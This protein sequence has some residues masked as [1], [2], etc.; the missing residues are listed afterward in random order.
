VR[1]T[2]FG[3]GYVGLTTG[4]MFAWLG[5]RVTLVDINPAKVA[6]IQAG[7]PPLF[8]E[9][10]APLLKAVRTQGTLDATEDPAAA[11]EADV[12]FIAVDT[13]PAPDGS[14]DMR[15][16]EAAS[17]AMGRHVDGTRL[18]VVVTKSTVPIGTA[19]LVKIW[20]EDGWRAAH[21]GAPLPDTVAV[22]SNPEF[23]REGQALFDSFYP[24]RVVVGADDPRAADVLETLYRPILAQDFPPPPGLPRPPE[25]TRVP[26]VR[27]DRVSAE[28]IKYAANAFLATKISFANEMARICDEVGAD[29]RLVTEA[30]GLDSR[31][32][33]QFLEAGVGWGGSCFGK[34][35]SALIH[36]AREYGLEPHLI[37]A[38]VTVNQIQRHWVVA[39]LQDALKTLRGRRVAL[40][41]LAFKPG[42][43]DLRD[44]PALTVLDDLLAVG[45]R[46]TAY[47]PVAA[48]R[49]QR[50]LAGR[51]VRFA[52]SALEAATGADA[53]A[54][55]TA[56]PEFRAVDLERLKAVMA[57]PVV[58]D[59]RN[60]FEP[61]D[62][63]ARGF[64]YRGV[65][66]GV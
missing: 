21:G 2:V 50:E 23:L 60:L 38:A 6:A 13:P 61:A 4:V 31:I 63:R 18:Q 28:M 54:I 52:A 49:A 40:W 22:A 8:E 42:T 3:A 7:E 34:D 9:H 56:W 66:R 43:D 33:R 57:T 44:S 45:A 37:A 27:A 11:R 16:V 24:D 5:N 55:V 58:V 15:H 19:N 51:D 65:G 64:L 47:D 35:L 25:R 41:G 59:G 32:G 14:A 20:I 29:I 12:L 36:T 46:V 62:M 39:R 48:E 17:V 1:V 30:I 53:V 10:L 26:L